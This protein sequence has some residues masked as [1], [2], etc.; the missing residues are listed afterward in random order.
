MEKQV[1]SPNELVKKLCEFSGLNQKELS[2]VLNISS[3]TLSNW[4]VGKT[5]NFDPSLIKRLG[6]AMRS[7]PGWG[8]KLGNITKSKIEIINVQDEKNNINN[9][10]EKT[11]E[12]QGLIVKLTREN[13]LLREKLETYEASK[14]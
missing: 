12:L 3:Q 14:Y 1:Y 10:S 2:K 4:S 8:I 11:N 7:N 6:V 9:N 5:K 13:L